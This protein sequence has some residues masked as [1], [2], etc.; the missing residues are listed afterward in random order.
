MAQVAILI[1][2]GFEDS[3]YLQPAAAFRAAGHQVV[4]VGLVAGVTVRGKKRAT[5]VQIDCAVAGVAVDD[6][7]ALLIPGGRSPAKLRSDAQA[8][9]LV[10]GFMATAKPVFAICHGPLLLVSARAIAGR[11][12]TGW[13]AIA[14]QLSGAGGDFSDQAVVVD[15]HLVSSRSPAD[16]APFIKAC[17]EQLARLPAQ[18]HLRGARRHL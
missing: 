14:P 9:A 17:L 2:D 11:K 10:R 13:K 3:E 16:L 1:S 5:P 4:T 7:D 18:G 12:I 6:F 8:V 15:H